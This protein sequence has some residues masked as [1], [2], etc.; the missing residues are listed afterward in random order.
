MAK[1]F[2]IVVVDTI[3][4]T[5]YGYIPSMLLPIF[6]SFLLDMTIVLGIA[7]GVIDGRHGGLEFLVFLVAG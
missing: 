7:A 2:Y 1:N 3:F 5:H 4:S 6:T